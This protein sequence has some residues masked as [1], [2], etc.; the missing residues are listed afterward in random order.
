MSLDSICMVV[1][2]TF[3]DPVVSV[4]IFTVVKDYNSVLG[5]TDVLYQGWSYFGILGLKIAWVASFS[6]FFIFTIFSSREHPLR[7]QYD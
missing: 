1:F 4:H 5:S 6:P 2:L 7:D 3:A